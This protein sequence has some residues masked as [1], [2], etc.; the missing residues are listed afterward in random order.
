MNI[1]GVNKQ[2]HDEAVSIFY[3]SNEFVF[4][5]PTQMSAFI[6]SLGRMRQRSIR[7]L[8]LQYTNGKAGGVDL[9]SITFPTLKLLK[10]LRQLQIVLGATLSAR[11][12]S[13]YR[14]GGNVWTTHLCN[15]CSLPGMKT[16]FE[17]RNI[18]NIKLRDT[19]LE[20]K[21]AVL[22]KKYPDGVPANSEGEAF[23]RLACILDHFNAA[24]ADAQ[25]GRVNREILNDGEWHMR[26]ELP[27]LLPVVEKA[28]KVEEPSAEPAADGPPADEDGQA[29]E[30]NTLAVT[31]VSSDGMRNRDIRDW[32]RPKSQLARAAPLTAADVKTDPSDDASEAA[33]GS[34]QYVGH[35]AEEDDEDTIV[36]KHVVRPAYAAAAARIGG[37]DG[38][39]EGDAQDQ[40]E[41]EDMEDSYA[42]RE[43]SVEL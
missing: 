14:P 43:P 25:K 21:V 18:T 11:I 37:L 42:D 16:L 17:L 38:A 41:D 4:Y 34:A 33:D 30:A 26:D 5:Y 15:P 32:F 10:G 27:V 29:V 2:I 13:Q 28:I 22:G 7:K 9:A 35:G 6:L 3:D 36:V 23:M 39:D 1:L 20:D 31:T 19:L 8:T 24:L 40:D 12:Y